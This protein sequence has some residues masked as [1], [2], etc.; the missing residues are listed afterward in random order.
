MAEVLVGGEVF[1]LV[2]EE[3]AEQKC[4]EMDVAEVSIMAL[5][6]RNPEAV[7]NSTEGEP[8]LVSEAITVIFHKDKNKIIVRNVYGANQVL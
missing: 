7:V 5:I 8:V 3:R 4:K 2:V 1:E 6:E